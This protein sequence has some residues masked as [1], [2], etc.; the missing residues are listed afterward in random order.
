MPLSTG[1]QIAASIVVFIGTACLLAFEVPVVANLIFTALCILWAAWIL[2]AIFRG[3]DEL[4]SA[5]VRYGLAMASGI[6]VPIV[7]ACVML[8]IL[9]PGLQGAITRISTF[10]GS[11]LSAAPLGFGMGV[12]FTVIVLCAVFAIGHWVWWTDKQQK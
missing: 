11:G 3:S 7:I 4:Q 12:T 1:S 9:T 6:G 5:S 2:I 8:M 10:S